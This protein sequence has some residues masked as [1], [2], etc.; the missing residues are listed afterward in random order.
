MKNKIIFGLLLAFPFISN[1]QT[2]K[3]EKVSKGRAIVAVSGGSVQVGQTY[4]VGGGSSGGAWGS[5]STSSGGG[6]RA[7]LLGLS[8]E[9][10]NL[11]TSVSGST[12]STPA[13]T[14]MALSGRYGWNKEIYEFGALLSYTN[15]SVSGT[16]TSAYE[17]GAFGDYNLTENKDPNNTIWGVG[18][19]FTFG[20]ETAS[21]STTS[22]SYMEFYVSGFGKFFVLGTSTAIRADVGYSYQKYNTTP[23]MTTSGIL[24][25]VG[26]AHYF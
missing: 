14:R 22:N 26:L 24:A 1:A 25:M 23:A 9:F 20:S 3:V 4:N 18:G 11:S 19:T 2:F 7:T 15:T 13:S 5:S 17:V 10:S 21:G 6:S 8:A 16:S 12:T